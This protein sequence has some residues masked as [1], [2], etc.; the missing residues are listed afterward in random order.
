MVIPPDRCQW[1]KLTAR[2]DVN[3]CSRPVPIARKRGVEVLNKISRVT[4]KGGWIWG[5]FG[6]RGNNKHFQAS[7]FVSFSKQWCSFEYPKHP[8]P[9]SN[10]MPEPSHIGIC[11]EADSGCSDCL[12]G[13][14]QHWYCWLRTLGKSQTCPTL[15][16]MLQK[17]TQALSPTS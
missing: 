1:G 13:K 3:H 12:Q 14:Y 5:L 17:K 16:V 7:C 15:N 8:V 10:R 11:N 4:A 9:N 6:G 2:T